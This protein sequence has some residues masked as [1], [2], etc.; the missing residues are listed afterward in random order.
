M[1]RFDFDQLNLLPLQFIKLDHKEHFFQR[2]PIYYCSRNDRPTSPLC[3][4]GAYRI[5]K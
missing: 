1:V 5:W 2:F 3:V 4:Y